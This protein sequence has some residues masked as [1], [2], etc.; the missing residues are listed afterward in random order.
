MAE[1]N[2]S[3]IAY[4]VSL[5]VE[6]LR[7]A[8]EPTDSGEKARHRLHDALREIRDNDLVYE[9]LLVAICGLA[10]ITDDDPTRL[11]NALELTADRML[12][13]VP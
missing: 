4:D 12:D 8:V 2:V 3:S 5:V 11:T 9:A 6:Q 1:V 10:K 7:R 13:L